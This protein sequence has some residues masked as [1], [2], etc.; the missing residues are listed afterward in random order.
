MKNVIVERVIHKGVNRVALR[1][2]YDAELISVVKRFPDVRWSKQMNCWHIAD[3]VDVINLLLKGLI[4]KAYV[5][6]SALKK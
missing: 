2:P 4:G 1:F 6:Y 5:D 3:S